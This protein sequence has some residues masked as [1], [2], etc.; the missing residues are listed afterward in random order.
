M[1][2][3]SIPERSVDTQF[4]LERLLETDPGETITYEEL[5][6]L[7]GRD[8]RPGGDAYPNL[9]SARRIAQHDHR[10]VFEAVRKVGIVRLRDDAIVRTAPGSI[11]RARRAALRGSKVLACVE[12]FD[13]LSDKDKLQHN[14]ALSVLGVIA[15]FAKPKSVKTVAAAVSDA[16]TRLP[17]ARTIAHFMQQNQDPDDTGLDRS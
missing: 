3:K 16:K 11:Q 4:L 8:V 5:T 9:F 6:D 14:T 1:E 17:V 13:N 7:I 10:I 12:D 2:K 15:H